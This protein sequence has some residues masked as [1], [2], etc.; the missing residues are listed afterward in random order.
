MNIEITNCIEKLVPNAKFYGVFVN[1]TEDEYNNI[2]WVD[3]RPKPTWENIITIK[4]DVAKEIKLE[5]I[6]LSHENSF[7]LGADTSFGFKV[8]CRPSDISNWTS[9][10]T[11]LQTLGENAPNIN[12]R[13][14]T[15]ETHELTFDQYKQ[16]CIELGNHYL[17][18]YYKKWDLEDKIKNAKTISD[19]EL[20]NWG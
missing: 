2:I 3:E 4:L 14:F 17:G 8:D 11:L 20:I 6:K 5:E 19:V 15:N 10:L 12:I 16:L 1:N 18:L 9:S 7:F 13:D